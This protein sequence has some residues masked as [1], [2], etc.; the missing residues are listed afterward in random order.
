MSHQ[1][2]TVSQTS[3]TGSELRVLFS[4]VKNLSDDRM[5]NRALKQ[6]RVNVRA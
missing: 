6:I 3:H 5:F 1:C 2:N 4:F